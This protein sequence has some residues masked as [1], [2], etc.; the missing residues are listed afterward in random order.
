MLNDK[1]GIIDD[2]IIYDLGIQENDISELLLI[3]NASRYEEDFQWIK[4]N[5][6]MSEIS[7]TNFKRQSTFSTTG[8]KLIRF[9]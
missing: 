9:I 1:G 6:N 4:N 7:I 5:L 3:V 8:K 2:L